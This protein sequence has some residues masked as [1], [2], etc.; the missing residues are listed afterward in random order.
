[1]NFVESQTFQNGKLQ[2]PSVFRM[3]RD[4]LVKSGDRVGTISARDAGKFHTPKNKEKYVSFVSPFETVENVS[5]VNCFD[6]F[7]GQLIFRAN[8][9]TI[10]ELLKHK[11]YPI[12]SIPRE[13]IEPVRK[14]IGI[15][16]E[17]KMVTRDIS[18][19][20]RQQFYI[21]EVQLIDGK[22]YFYGYKRNC[23]KQK[24]QMP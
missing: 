6:A 14:E 8:R 13:A 5:H 7:D 10:K 4:K 24:D 11:K 18:D 1:M 9:K 16:A 21:G 23:P 2:P 17:Q 20:I 15:D 22:L 19:E 3:D 12:S